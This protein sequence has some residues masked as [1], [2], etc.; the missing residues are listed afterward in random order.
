MAPG[1]EPEHILVFAPT[2]R[3]ASLAC[4]ALAGAGLHARACAGV[5]DLATGIRQGAGAA[6][7][8]EEAL[9]PHA[10]G[11]LMAQLA[12]Q[13]P[14]S[15]FPVILMGD[16][17]TLAR[18]DRRLV[19]DANVT[20]LERPFR[21]RT[22][23]A[24]ARA[25]LRG[26][27]RQYDAA[28][29]IRNRDQFLAMLGHELRNPLAA[30]TFALQ[31]LHGPATEQL[32][33]TQLEVLGRQAGRLTR[34]VDDLLDVARVT[35][36]KVQVR[37]EPAQLATI[38]RRSAE[39]MAAAAAAA[40]L[41]LDVE[42]RDDPSVEA[43]AVRLEQVFTN[44][45]ANAIKFTPSGGRIQVTVTSNGHD[46]VAAVRDTGVGIPPDALHR[47]FELFAQ[48]ETTLDRSRGGLGLGLTLARSLVELHG[49]ALCAHSEGPG[50]GSEFR[51]TLPLA[52]RRE[53]RPEPGRVPARS[54]ACRVVVVE[55]NDDIRQA[56]RCLLESSGHEVHEA[57]DGAAGVEAIVGRR[58][59][60]A[61]V[62]IGLPALDGYEVARRVRPKV[63]PDVTLVALTGYGQPEDRAR[64]H[65]AGFDEHLTKPVDM[66]RLIR[67]LEGA[68]ARM[69]APS[70]GGND[71]G[72]AFKGGGHED[73]TD[74]QRPDEPDGPRECDHKG[75]KGKARP[76]HP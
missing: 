36:G 74:A 67:V 39:T 3:D 50:K 42:V 71:A 4:D 44:L 13:P 24:A 12:S 37:R 65:E 47:I 35:S 6:I 15:D 1:Q 55:D 9:T 20:I 33:A 54:R 18:R 16:A 7:I 23:V 46:A 61:F 73:R 8:S 70:A 64:A 27:R 25:A 32:K 51:V 21:I 17:E 11:H 10:V 69:P 52:A 58:P 34:L 45:L 31:V 22:L 48:V 66:A 43:D 40:G 57:R 29:A 53:G 19:D 2:G 38:V 28:R 68:R 76:M 56:F 72:R 41:R 62:D 49:G 59:A 60:V 75:A 63:G 30:M 14:W 26:R 5:E